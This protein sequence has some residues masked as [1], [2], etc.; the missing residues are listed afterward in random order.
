[1]PQTDYNRYGAIRAGMPA[2]GMG[3]QDAITR[4]C[5]DT[6]LQFG[7]GLVEGTDKLLQCKAADNAASKFIGISGQTQNVVGEYVE[8]DAVTVYGRGRIGVQVVAGDTPAVGDPAYIV[9]AA[10]ADRGKFTTTITANLDAGLVFGTTKNSNNFAR[11]T[12]NEA[13]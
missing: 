9:V 3:G 8:D 6:T 7:L 11:I 2:E 1:M 5:E 4:I 13:I 12:V 10:G